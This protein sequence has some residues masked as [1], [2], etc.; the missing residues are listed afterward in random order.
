MPILKGTDADITFAS[1]YRAG[2]QS[3]EVELDAEIIETTRLGDKWRTK[4]GGVR[5][6]RG[7]F[8]CQIES[9]SN[10]GGAGT[11]SGTRTIGMG[12]GD[13]TQTPAAA[14]FKLGATNSIIGNIIVTR[15]RVTT[16]VGN[17]QA[18]AVAFDFEGSDIPHVEDT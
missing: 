11:T 6:W 2:A 18:S 13:T 8:T 3:W 5:N 16:A 12:A 17:G 14:T 1:G 10:F 15:A 7:S 9:G 4:I